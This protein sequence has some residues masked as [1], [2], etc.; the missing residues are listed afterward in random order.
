MAGDPQKGMKMETKIYGQITKRILFKLM[1]GTDTVSLQDVEDKTVFTVTDAA[2]LF[3]DEGEEGRAVLFFVTESGYYSTTS[4]T[5]IKTFLSAVDFF[6]THRLT[7]R[8][9]TG[10]SKAGRTFINLDEIGDPEN[11]A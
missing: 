4:P 2:Y 9:V 3:P 5:A 8:K 7:C 11:D 10:K 6:G 1:Q